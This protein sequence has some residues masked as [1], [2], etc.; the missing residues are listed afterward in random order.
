VARAPADG[1]TLMVHSITHLSNGLL[2]RKVPY[3][4]VN[5][6]T[7]VA[8]L[9][10]Q[11]GVLVVHP[12]LPVKT[13]KQFIALAKARPNEITYGSNGPGGS[14]HLMMALFTSMANVKL[15]HVPYKGG[16]PLTTSLISGE[17]QSATA[18]I[19]TVLAHIKSS[20]LRALGVTA[21]TRSG[22]LPD[23]PTIAEAGV[24]GYDHGPWN[25]MLLPARTPATIVNRLNA[26][27]AKA[28]H[29]PDV[30]AAL[31]Q[32][33]AEPVGNRPEEFGKMIRE[34][35]VKWAKVIKAANITAD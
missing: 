8:L 18:T 2:I 14:L 19:N 32:E 12:A 5:D 11:P 4:T 16:A 30:K 10:A 23:V 24:P 33:G 15:I 20:R 7:P 31:A 28:I 6:F 35:T 3:D 27:S 29:L 17:T 25:G 13:V 22:L 34:E 1:Y 9:V 21:D 26:A